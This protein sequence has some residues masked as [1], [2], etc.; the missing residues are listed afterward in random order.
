MGMLDKL[1]AKVA[2]ER[3]SYRMSQDHVRKVAEE[4]PFPKGYWRM[5]DEQI[6]AW[7]RAQK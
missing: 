4:L 5:T 6:A 1:K 2:H 3:E 7:R